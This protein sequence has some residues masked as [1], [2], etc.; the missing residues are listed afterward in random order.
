MQAAQGDADPHPVTLDVTADE[1][2][3]VIHV[4]NR[5]SARPVARDGMGIGTHVARAIV[6]AHG[7]TLTRMHGPDGMVHAALSLPLIEIR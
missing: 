5:A 3:A 6:E 2:Q 1:T 7:G 4:V